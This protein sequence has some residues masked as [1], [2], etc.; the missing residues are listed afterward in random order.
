[1][2]H[3]SVPEAHGKVAAALPRRHHK[4]PG[5]VLEGDVPQPRRV[6]PVGDAGVD[7]DHHRVGATLEQVEELGPSR[8]VL[9]E[10]EAHT[11][12]AEG[13]GGE[14]P[15]DVGHRFHGHERGGLVD[16]EHPGHHR[17]H[18]GVGEVASPGQHEPDRELPAVGGDEHVPAQLGVGARTVEPAPA[19]PVRVSAEDDPPGAFGTTHGVLAPQLPR[20]HP[21][22]VGGPCAPHTTSG[23]SALATTVVSRAAESAL[24]QRAATIRTSLTRSSWS[25][26][27][28]SSATTSGCTAS[29]TVPRYPSSTS[30]TAGT[31]GGADAS[32]VANPGGRL[33]PADEVATRGAPPRAAASRRVVVV[34]PLVPVTRATRRPSARV[35][36]RSGAMRS[37]TRPPMTDPPPR[38]S[39]RDAA[40]T[41]VE[42][43]PARRARTGSERSAGRAV[44]SRRDRVERC[45]PA[46]RP[47]ARAGAGPR[48]GA[49]S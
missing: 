8:R 5:Q 44:T 6:A 24:R 20:R 10:Q 21:H 16:A 19:R 45:G 49:G 25:R 7:A 14:A 11:N 33:A 30:S 27:R 13:H 18:R 36:R 15:F 47:W 22:H 42:A 31:P 38:C 41:A 3:A 9:G 2:R 28:L 40:L 39:R 32:A 46:P 48:R 37:P 43:R 12:V 1:M 29:A 17:R 35:P 23:S 26:D 4:A 34:L